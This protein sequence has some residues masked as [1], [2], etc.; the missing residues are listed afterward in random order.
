MRLFINEANVYIKEDKEGEEV[1]GDM[2]YDAEDEDGDRDE[3]YD[4]DADSDDEEVGSSDGF[5]L[6]GMVANSF[7]S[8]FW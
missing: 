6:V 3:G 5:E 4:R 2:Y 8:F 7:S 1:D